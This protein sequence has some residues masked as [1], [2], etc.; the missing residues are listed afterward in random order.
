LPV[1]LSLFLSV[2]LCLCLC[3]SACVSLC[4]SDSVSLCLCLSVCLSLSISVSLYLS[5]PLSLFL[6][7]C[8]CIIYI[9]LRLCCWFFP[10]LVSKV[11]KSSHDFL[12]CLPFHFVP[13]ST[14]Q[15]VSSNS[16]NDRTVANSY[17]FRSFS[18]LKWTFFCVT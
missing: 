3:L 5:L 2:C 15:A 10:S 14:E 18:R 1:S 4:F 8:V 13:T 17:T 12:V 9:L 11:L 7:V 6:W 16:A